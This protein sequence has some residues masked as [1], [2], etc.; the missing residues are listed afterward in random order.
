MLGQQFLVLVIMLVQVRVTVH[1]FLVSVGVFMD[2]V[3]PK[4]KI[5]V[6]KEIFGLT[7][8]DDIM[9]GS[10]DK[11]PAGNFLYQIQVLSTEN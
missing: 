6:G 1:Q 3:S 9:F 8:V 10:H 2:K 5:R 4:E 11:Y 7:I